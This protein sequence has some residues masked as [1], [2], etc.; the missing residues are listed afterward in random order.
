MRASRPRT[1]NTAKGRKSRT[2]V[3]SNLNQPLSEHSDDVI[4]AAAKR[5]QEWV[6]RPVDVRWRETKQRDGH[7]ARPPNSFMLY[8]SAYIPEAKARYS[9]HKQQNLSAIVGRSWHMESQKVRQVYEAYAIIERSNHRKAY[10]NYKFSPRKSTMKKGV[11]S[12]E[13]EPRAISEDVYSWCDSPLAVA[14]NKDQ[15]WDTTPC[16]VD[17]DASVRSTAPGAFAA[18]LPPQLTL[19]QDQCGNQAIQYQ[20]AKNNVLWSSMTTTP[21]CQEPCSVSWEPRMDSMAFP[22]VPNTNGL[23]VAS[24]PW[25]G[26]EMLAGA[27]INYTISAQDPSCCGYPY[28]WSGSA[29]LP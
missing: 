1:A 13:E 10:P 20:E 21:P 19:W 3:C 18:W 11:T 24:R 28:T 4:E 29:A 25:S 9:Q 12:S 7:I 15:A 22:T 16:P 6:N 14:A 17:M 8:R 2:L 27:G 5:T 23:P 26:A